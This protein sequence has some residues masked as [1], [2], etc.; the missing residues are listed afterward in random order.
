MK[1]FKRIVLHFFD[2]IVPAFLPLNPPCEAD[3]ISPVLHKIHLREILVD[4]QRLLAYI[5]SQDRSKELLLRNEYLVRYVS[6]RICYLLVLSE[7][8]Q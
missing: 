3:I 4:W 5:S 1:I 2:G 7:S 6:T 8:A